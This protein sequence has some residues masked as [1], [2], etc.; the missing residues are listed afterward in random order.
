MSEVAI[1]TIVGLLVA[2]ALS[3]ILMLFQR[4]KPDE[5]WEGTVVGIQPF[6]K[7]DQEGDELAYVR[8]TF[9]LNDSSER[10]LTLSEY[11]FQKLFPPL[12]IGERLIK[13][14]GE[15]LPTRIPP[16]E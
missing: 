11:D 4:R 9:R 6:T 1:Y 8:I 15:T 13:K 7:T 16:A 2:A 5:A 3:A 10:T 12:R 14:P